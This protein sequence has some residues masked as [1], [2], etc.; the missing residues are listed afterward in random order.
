MTPAIYVQTNDASDNEIVAFSRS[1]E[2]QLAPLGRYSTGGRG[3]GEP[4]L[5]SQNSIV[6]SDDGRWLLVAN[7]GSDDLS[8]FA[9][10]SDGLRLEDRVDSGGS[11]PTSV[12]VSGE[13]VYV[14]NNGTPCITGFNLANGKLT[15]LEDSTRQLSADDADPAQIS[16]SVDGAALIATERG[17]NSISSYAIDERGYAEGPTTIES[18]GQ[19]P[20]GFDFTP[21]GS[22]IVTEAFGGAAG[23][24]AASSY[25]VAGGGEL[26]A[27]SGSVGDTRSEVCWAAVTN[28]GQY[29]YV[30]NFGDCT[31]SC[32]EIAG[33]GSLEL[34]DPVAASTRQGEKGLRDEAISGDGR[35]LYAID[36]DAQKVFGWTVG[37]DG[38]LTSV[39]EFEG[40]PETV[41]GLAAS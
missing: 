22:L 34:R 7:S 12:A 37:Q 14:L 32:Y 1:E 31:V 2:G 25:A 35:Y 40:V 15:P 4:H 24:A 9:I 30:T 39:G 13:L 20:Y 6:I 5:P 27:V 28:D 23:A 26:S 41:A 8:L 19:T 38:G 3:T 16:F 17:T 11:K 33:D 18:K 21:K 36:A 29:A 10:E